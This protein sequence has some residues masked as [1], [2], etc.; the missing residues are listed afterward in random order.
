MVI[1]YSF[2]AFGAF[3]FPYKVVP[4]GQRPTIRRK[5]NEIG[6]MKWVVVTLLQ[7]NMVETQS[8]K[9]K[10]LYSRTPQAL[11]PPV[12]V[13]STS[14]LG[15]NTSLISYDHEQVI[16]SLILILLNCK[17]AIIIRFPSRF[18]AGFP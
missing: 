8:L 13:F 6:L 2:C 7:K 1:F 15:S 3:G 17:T 10:S 14:D 11:P 5:E 4:V 12:S 9:K 16:T 18:V